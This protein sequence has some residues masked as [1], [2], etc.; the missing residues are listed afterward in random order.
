[1]NLTSSF[2]KSKKTLTEKLLECVSEYD[3]F[4]TFIGEDLKVGEVILSPI[5]KDNNPTFILFIPKDKD[6]VFF[7]DFAW[8]GGNV[9]KFIKLFA[10]YQDSINLSSR[11]DI[12]RYI[13][14]RMQLGLFGKR[15]KEVIRRKI[16]PS[17]Y[18]ANR[19]IR[20]KSRPLTSRDK[21]YWTQY[22][23]TEDT[24]EH[25]NVRSVHKII[26]DIGEVIYTV[27]ARTLCFAY[28]IYNKV[29]LYSPEE[30]SG[31]KWRN[32][33][34]AYY[35][36]GLEQLKKS[37][38]KNKKLIIT[39]SLK[40]I[41]VFYTFLSHEYDIL[42][43]HS[44]TYIFPDKLLMSFYR[45]YDEIIVIFD[46][47]LAG[48]TGANRLCKK[49]ARIRAVFVSTKRMLVNKKLK[50]IDKDI[51]DYAVGRSREDIKK[52]LLKIGL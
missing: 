24:L 50:V 4:C 25:Y 39:K 43:P 38:S 46:Y 45:K 40:D 44:E 27:P 13:D 47:D 12:I 15:K 21:E 52:Q 34:P 6:E 42:A 37:K 33:C 22:H 20:F 41:M 8:I 23:I 30:K 9:F 35:L 11:L 17:F 19:T 26:N 7:K 49:D 32:N 10:L 16:D 48:V 29:K 3:I 31:F 51:S 5:R 1:M 2:L 18:T 14:A 36:Q 28:V